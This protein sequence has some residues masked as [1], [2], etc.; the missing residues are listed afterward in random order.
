[1]EIQQL[2]LKIGKYWMISLLSKD[3][4][5]GPYVTCNCFLAFW[6]TP[7]YRWKGKLYSYRLVGSCY[8]PLRF[9]F[10]DWFTANIQPLRIISA[11]ENSS[12]WS[13]STTETEAGFPKNSVSGDWEGPL[14]VSFV[15]PSIPFQL[16][17]F[18]QNKWQQC[19]FIGIYLVQLCLLERDWKIPFCHL[20]HIE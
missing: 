3:L 15:F 8:M 12:I 16:G 14:H 13:P 20:H 5:L 7:I 1:M 17:I 19:A 9:Q 4:K 2:G 10:I 18:V 6:Y 11:L